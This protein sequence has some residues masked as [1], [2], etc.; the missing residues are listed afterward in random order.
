MLWAQYK[1]TAVLIETMGLKNTFAKSEKPK[2]TM[3]V[4]NELR[5][6]AYDV[7]ILENDMFEN[8]CMF[9]NHIHNFCDTRVRPNAGR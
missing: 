5:I 3:G 9:E 8:V 2:N 7:G 1:L 6:F 4:E